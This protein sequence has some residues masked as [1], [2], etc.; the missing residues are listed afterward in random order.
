MPTSWI[1][2]IGDIGLT[3]KFAFTIDVNQ[4]NVGMIP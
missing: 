3:E 2:L 4:Y 1:L